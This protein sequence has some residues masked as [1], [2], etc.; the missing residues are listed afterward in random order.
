MSDHG[1]LDGLLQ[2]RD[3]ECPMIAVDDNYVCVLEYVDEE[4]GGLRVLEAFGQRRRMGGLAA[5][6]AAFE[7][8]ETSAQMT[9]LSVIARVSGRSS[10]H[11]TMLGAVPCSSLRT[12]DI[13]CPAFAGHDS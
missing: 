1:L 12:V 10:T 2:C 11:Q 6:F 8:D 9:P 13:G 5:A 4:I 7:G 3:H